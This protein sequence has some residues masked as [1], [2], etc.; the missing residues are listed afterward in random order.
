M[1]LPGA[2]PT[3][4]TP[5]SET[6]Y[7]RQ[8]LAAVASDDESAMLDAL[9]RQLQSVTN[10][11]IE[12]MTYYEAHHTLHDLR[13]AVPPALRGLDTVVGWPSMVVDVLDERLE[14]DGFTAADGSELPDWDEIWNE[15]GMEAGTSEAH[16]PALVCGMG[17]LTVGS[18]LADEPEQLLTV[19]S[20]LTT[21]VAWDVRARRAGAAA[22]FAFESG[23]PV[24]ATLYLPDRTV[25]VSRIQN[26]WVVDG[27]DQHN[28]GVVPVFPFINRASALHPFGR[29]E[30]TRP[31]IGLTDSAVRTVVGMEVS[32]EFYSA[33]QRYLLGAKESAFKRPDGTVISG[34]EAIMGR[35]LAISRDQDGNVPTVGQFPATSPEPYVGQLAT[36]SQ[37]LAAEAAI[38]VHYLGF[39]TD[40]PASGD[41]I[42]RGEVRLIK[43]TDRR[44]RAFGGLGWGPAMRLA[45]ALRTGQP[46]ETTPPVLPV[47]EDSGMPTVGAAADAATKLVAAGVLPAADD[48]TWR[49][50]G[51][52]E[53][54]R[55]H[56]TEWAH[57]EADRAAQAAAQAAAQLQ[58]A[59]AGV[60]AGAG[61]GGFGGPMQAQG[62]QTPPPP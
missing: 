26:G 56:L 62:P 10:H 54:D 50:L 47:W 36:L 23:Q 15:N 34:W 24:Q 38:P 27:R 17:F 5:T 39:V 22:N 53:A 14:I 45:L 19:Q 57:G 46:W 37:L 25:Q 51:L 61:G 18:G 1:T 52:S 29:S 31:I 59:V 16:V 42:R 48:V 43:R 40:N 44:K 4:L 9:F 49:M 60:G 30:I 6:Y 32:R 2:T 41:A 11:N 3:P 12:K 8:V 20:P 13:I 33:P 28:L 21:T 55:A 35:M 7:Q 58:A